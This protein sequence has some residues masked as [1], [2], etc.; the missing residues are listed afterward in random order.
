MAK[1]ELSKKEKQ[2]TVAAL[3]TALLIW[4]LWFLLHHKSQP[5]AAQETE[6]ANTFNLGPLVPPVLN[7]P[8]NNNP[9]VNAS[10]VQSGCGCNSC[11]SCPENP[12]TIGGVNQILA[13]ST[14]TAN[15]ILQAGNSTLQAL[16][17][18]ANQ[19]DPLVKVTVG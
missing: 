11:S 5:A 3:L 16:A 18:I 2:W 9:A 7:V 1:R 12:A 19:E 10:P 6:P 17:T 15:M 4:L 13:I 14:A 8:T